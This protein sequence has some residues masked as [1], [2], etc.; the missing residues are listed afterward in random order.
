MS[1]NRRQ[2]TRI[3]M[4]SSASFAATSGIFFP[5][6]VEAFSLNVF[7]KDL[8][9]RGVFNDILRY[10]AARLISGILSPL[11]EGDS[12]F[13][14]QIEPGAAPVIRAV[15]NQFVRYQF[16]RDRTELIQTG[17]GA[18]NSLLWGRERQDKWGPNVAFGFVQKYQDS[19]SNTKI[20]GP[21]LT[22]IHQATKVLQSQGL[23]PDEIQGSLLPI[24][25]KF[26]A[27][28]GWEGDNDPSVGLNSG[29]GF[30]QYRTV[31]GEVTSRYDLI[32][33]GSGGLGRVQTTVEAGGQ[34][35]RNI[36]VTVNF[37]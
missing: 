7:L 2:F 3:A 34:P 32:E 8:S 15:D 11:L 19:F 28:G 26:D 12:D 33:P 22:G 29:V 13:A 37:A 23:T 20:T 5:K 31:L 25:S 14:N 9:A 21:H 18:V 16:T 4:L 27:L 24:R 30:T 6:P 35:R 17:S 10:T 1:I 36:L